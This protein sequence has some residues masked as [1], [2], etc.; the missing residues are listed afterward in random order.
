MAPYRPGP[1]TSHAD[2]FP[3]SLDQWQATSISP[4]G[5]QQPRHQFPHPCRQILDFLWRFHLEERKNIT[6]TL[7]C[8]NS[9]P[10][11]PQLK[12]LSRTLTRLGITSIRL[13]KGHLHTHMLIKHTYTNTCIQAYRHTDTHTYSYMHAYVLLT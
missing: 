8:L 9:F 10:F 13:L 12:S 4:T 11:S 6:E 7:T 3:Y 2:C 1:C 5:Q